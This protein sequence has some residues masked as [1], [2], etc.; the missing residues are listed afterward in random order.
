MKNIGTGIPSEPPRCLDTIVILPDLETMGVVAAY[1]VIM[2]ID[3]IIVPVQAGR[4][5]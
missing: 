4:Q 2:E 5:L 3:S 1:P